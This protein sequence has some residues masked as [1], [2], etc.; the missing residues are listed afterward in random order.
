MGSL[1]EYSEK[2]HCCQVFDDEESRGQI[3]QGGVEFVISPKEHLGLDAKTI[4]DLP[5]FMFKLSSLTNDVKKLDN[6]ME[7]ECS[8]CL[9]CYE[10]EEIV[11][12]MPKCHHGFHSPCLDKWLGNCST[13]PLCRSSVDSSAVLLLKHDGTDSE[14]LKECELAVG[15]IALLL[16]VSLITSCFSSEI[17]LSSSA[18]GDAVLVQINKGLDEESIQKLPVFLF[19]E[20]CTGT[21]KESECPICLGLFRDDEMVKLL[22]DCHHTYHAEC[23]DKWLSCH[24]NCPLCRASLQLNSTE[25]SAVT[26]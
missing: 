16:L 1:T 4:S 5:I 6:Y 21:V 2:F 10:D 18:S 23:I 26:A 8:I 22:P 25:I 3:R 19:G 14:R 20:T 11:K 17:V 13:C 7:S 12:M 24:S 15:V 9:G